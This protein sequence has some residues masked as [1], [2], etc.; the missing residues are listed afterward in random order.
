MAG[1]GLWSAFHGV[2]NLAA[3]DTVLPPLHVLFAETLRFSKGSG[4][5]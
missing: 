5:D 1:A 4:A 3:L 2:Q